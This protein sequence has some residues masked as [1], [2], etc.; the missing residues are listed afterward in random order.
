MC[1]FVCLNFHQGLLGFLKW[2]RAAIRHS[3]I[4]FIYSRNFNI[5]MLFL[6]VVTKTAIIED[7]KDCEDNPEDEVV[8]A[9]QEKLKK[10]GFSL[11][12]VAWY[13]FRPH[14]DRGIENRNNIHSDFGFV[15]EE[16]LV[17]E[18]KWL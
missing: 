4:I 15:F 9:L 11:R 8:I 7:W 18:I 6:K 12:T 13:F 3:F 17:S 2:Q 1:A 10:E 14:Y 16:K 5:E